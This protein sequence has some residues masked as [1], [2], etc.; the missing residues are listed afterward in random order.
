MLTLAQAKSLAEG[1]KGIA[2]ADEVKNWQP[3]LAPTLSALSPRMEWLEKLNP[4]GSGVNL[5]VDLKA[6]REQFAADVPNLPVNGW[7]PDGDVHTATRVLTRYVSEGPNMPG[8]VSLRDTHRVRIIPLEQLPLPILQGQAAGFIRMSF[9][10]GFEA[11]RFAPGSVRDSLLRGHFR[12]ATSALEDLKKHLDNART[13]MDQDKELQKDFE[14]WADEFQRLSAKQIRAGAR[15]RG[16]SGG[17]SRDGAFS[18]L[19]EEPGH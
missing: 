12:E 19:P 10:Q 9:A 8:N 11:L 13:R 3:F 5:Y 7:N 2:G 1:I 6:L 4:G 15:P 17:T 18:R 16:A 14:T